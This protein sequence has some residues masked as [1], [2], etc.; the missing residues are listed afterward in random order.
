MTQVT[1]THTLRV[2]KTLHSQ[3]I[4]GEKHCVTKKAKLGVLNVFTEYEPRTLAHLGLRV[5]TKFIYGQKGASQCEWHKTYFS[6]DSR[7]WWAV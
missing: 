6:I 5:K 2:T 7:G 4:N 3:K 1:P